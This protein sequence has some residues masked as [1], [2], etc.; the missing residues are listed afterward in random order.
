MKIHPEVQKLLV[1]FGIDKRVPEEFRNYYKNKDFKD[2]EFFSSSM[3]DKED[4][5]VIVYNKDSI[6]HKLDVLIRESRKDLLLSKYEIELLLCKRALNNYKNYT[7][8]N[9]TIFA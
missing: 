8:D 6:D 4:V 1:E 2:I 5:V 7:L 9:R 3:G